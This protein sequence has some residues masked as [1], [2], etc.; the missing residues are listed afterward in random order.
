MKKDKN[1]KLT[2]PDLDCFKIKLSMKDAYIIVSALQHSLEHI[3]HLVDQHELTSQESIAALEMALEYGKV[4]TKIM[5][6]TQGIL[7]D[8]KMEVGIKK[9]SKKDEQNKKEIINKFK[10]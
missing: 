8:F 7:G 9:G 4:L 10:K 3:K 5:E 1:K 6:G 2:S